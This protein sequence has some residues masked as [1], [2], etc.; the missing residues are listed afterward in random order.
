MKKAWVYLIEIS[1]DPALIKKNSAPDSPELEALHM[2]ALELLEKYPRL[3]KEPRAKYKKT[4]SLAK[5]TL[6]KGEKV[7]VWTNFLISQQKLSDYFLA[8]GYQS[9]KINGSIPKDDDE[10]FEFNKEK[11]IEKFKNNSEFNVLI[12]IPASLAESVSLHKH[13]HHAIYVDR[14]Y[15]GGHYMQ[16]LKRIHRVET[17]DVIT[18]YDIIESENSID[19]EIA[20]NL[21]IKK[22]DMEAFYNTSE[23][24][25]QDLSATGD[26]TESDEVNWNLQ[27][28]E[29]EIKGSLKGILDHLNN[30]DEEE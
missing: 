22:R 16:S 19:Q 7:I 11:E 1:I 27:M 30:H 14:T 28:N 3:R 21:G 4:I 10:N 6:E 12:A 26:S 13:C 25:V 20:V 9:V 2:N 8:E 5:E 23:L 15:N 24:Y 18:R 17:P 29:D